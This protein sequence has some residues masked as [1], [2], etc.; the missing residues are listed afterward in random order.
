MELSAIRPKLS[1]VIAAWN[2]ARL[3][4]QCLTSLQEQV[5]AVDPEI[6]VASNFGEE[7]AA[8]IKLLF[9]RVQYIRLAESATVPQLRAGGIAAA[10]GEIVLRHCRRRGRKRE[11]GEFNKLGRLFL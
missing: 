7:S 2:N 9:P 8:Q 6:I 4:Q 11:R 1:V 10:R 5:E 3:L